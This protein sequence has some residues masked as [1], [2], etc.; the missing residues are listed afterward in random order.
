MIQKIKD[1]FANRKKV[2]E[3]VLLGKLWLKYSAPTTITRVEVID[4]QGRRYTNYDVKKLE[5]S[6]QDNERTMKIFI[7]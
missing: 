5:I 7:D 1:Y 2:K 6:L 4:K 3:K